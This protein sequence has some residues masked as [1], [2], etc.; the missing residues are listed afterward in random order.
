MQ[1]VPRGNPNSRILIVGEAPG[2][3]EVAAGIPFVGASGKELSRMLREAGIDE[4][5]CRFTNMVNQQPPN[6]K[7]DEFFFS[8]KKKSAEGGGI[9]HMGRYCKP[10]ILEGLQELRQEVAA[11]DP[12]LIIAFGNSG[13]WATTGEFGITK[14][15]GSEMTSHLFHRPMKVIPTYHPAAILRNWDYRFIAVQ[16]LRRAKREKDTAHVTVPSYDFVIR[17]TVDHVLRLLSELTERAGKEHLTLS[18]DIE[19]RNRQIACI[20]IAWSA[21]NAI[22]IPIQSVETI[23]YW[24]QSEEVA[25]VWALHKLLTHTNVSV[26]GQNFIYDNQY[27]ARNY[28]FICN[29]REDTMFQQH[30]AY[31]GLPKG[32]DF[33]SSMYREHHLY[34]KD[35][36]KNWD[37]K[38]H[39]EDQLWEYNCLDAVATYEAHFVLR[40]VLDHYQLQPQYREKMR[41]ASNAFRMMLRGVRSNRTAKLQLSSDL[42]KAIA[43]NRK[44]LLRIVKMDIFGPKGISSKKMMELAYDIMRL[45]TKYRIVKGQRF[46]T[47]NKEAIDEW[48]ETCEPIFRPILYII[49]ATRSMQVF[50]STFA[51]QELDYDSRFRCSFNPVGAHT[52]RWTSSE[53][54]FNY[55]GNLQNV[56]KGDER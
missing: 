32:L 22:C 41:T 40:D 2:Q 35:E 19:T 13:L 33:I 14:W 37:P 9:Y 24:T 48:L 18:V 28:G 51:D 52:M 56:P 20:G 44:W 45:P 15:R 3:Q 23:S 21:L 42:A 5:S 17:P 39:N 36:G 31:P 55:G 53:D 26:V 6:N 29:L 34:W 8:S 12:N 47:A 10:I 1:V 38:V 43:L 25:I 4:T 27:F 16:D 49:K 11:V 30:I 7:V 50:K 46:R 54:A